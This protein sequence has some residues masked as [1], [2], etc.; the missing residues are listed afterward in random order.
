MFSFV[1]S[2]Y[3]TQSS[4]T[5]NIENY[6]IYS[7]YFTNDKLIYKIKNDHCLFKL[8]LEEV[9]NMKFKNWEANRQFDEGRIPPIAEGIKQSKLVDSV[10]YCFMNNK[11]EFEIYDGIHRYSAC[12]RIASETDCSIE[13][14]SIP[15]LI[16]V[17]FYKDVNEVKNSFHRI[18]SGIPVPTL[19]LEEE[20][21]KTLK[22]KQKIEYSISY[23]TEHYKKMFTP[24]KPQKGHENR[25]RMIEK[26]SD[27]IDQSDK[28]E[29][30]SN[31]EFKDYLMQYNMRMKESFNM[32]NDSLNLTDRQK[33]KCID[34]DCYMFIRNGGLWH[35]H[36]LEL[37]GK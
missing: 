2:A 13:D 6:Q 12:K 15:C 11:Y 34:N 17:M 29:T 35:Y 33:K 18:N 4:K 31:N 23:F 27:I 7:K 37:F 22:K 5:S 25:D 9:N 24:K 26:L 14:M 10:I 8:T 19:Y 32:L 36:F 30:C 21:Q 28:F 1:S 3:G 16:N 20:N